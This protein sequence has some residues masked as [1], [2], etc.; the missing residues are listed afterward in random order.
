MFKR[1]QVSIQIL[2]AFETVYM[3]IFLHVVKYSC[4]HNMKSSEGMRAPEAS[5]TGNYEVPHMDVRILKRCL[6][7]PEIC[8]SYSYECFT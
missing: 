7:V 6:R 2:S 5:A 4:V 8:A 3:Y 1:F